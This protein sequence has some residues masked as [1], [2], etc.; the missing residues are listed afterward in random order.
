[1]T[2]PVFADT[3]LS[4]QIILGQSQEGKCPGGIVV[5]KDPYHHI[6]KIYDLVAEPPASILRRIGLR[7]YLPQENMYILDAGCGTGTQLKLLSKFGCK[8]YG[9][10]ASPAMLGAARRKLGDIAELSLQDITHMNFPD[11]MFDLVTVVLVLHEVPASL[12]PAVLTECKRVLRA[13]GRILVIDYHFESYSFL[14][15]SIL[16]VLR[17]LVEMGVGREHYANYR[18]YQKREGLMPLLADTKLSIDKRIVALGG[19]AAVYLL[20]P[21]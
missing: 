11:Q 7:L 14:L 19:V 18:N 6:V 17:R 13:D 8:L 3:H 9:V 21:V 1:M 12:R 16:R 15:G 20:R 2:S 10:D 4:S 5:K